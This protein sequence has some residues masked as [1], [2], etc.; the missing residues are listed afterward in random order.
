MLYGRISGQ[1]GQVFMWQTDV[2]SH[3]FDTADANCLAI[4]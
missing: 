2:A 4:W 3:G 1:A